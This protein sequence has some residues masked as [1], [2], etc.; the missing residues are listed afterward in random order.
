MKI[1]ILLGSARKVRN[2]PTIGSVIQLVASAQHPELDFEIV[3]LKEWKIPFDAEEFIPKTGKYTSPEVGLW[4][5]KIESADGFVV[6]APQYNWGYPAVLKNALDV[7]YNEFS[8]KPVLIATFGH[9]GGNKCNAQLREVLGGGFGM[10]VTNSGLQI[11][12]DKPAI[13]AHELDEEKVLSNYKEDIAA[14]LEEL[15]D[16]LRP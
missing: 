1:I 12:I 4:S 16:L 7:L 13:M 3:D 15:R 5:S 11:K 9:H 10:K 14:A 8:S 2:T 6:V